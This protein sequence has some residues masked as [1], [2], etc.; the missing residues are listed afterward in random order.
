MAYADVVAGA[1]LPACHEIRQRVH[2]QTFDRTLQW[3]C[4]VPDVGPFQKQEL[5]RARH[6]VYVEWV[7]QRGCA[8][9]LLDD[10][11]FEVDDSA[12]FRR[13]L[14]IGTQRYDPAGSRTQ[15]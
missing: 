9:P 11:Q 7:A 3:P 12:Q 5:F 10:L 15:A 2:K 6:H 8:D 14:E 4:P 13:A 1:D